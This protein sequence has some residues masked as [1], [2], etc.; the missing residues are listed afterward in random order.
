MIRAPFLSSIYA[1][2]IAGTLIAVIA[3]NAFAPVNF[4]L[5]L[6]IG[7]GLHIAT[8]VYNDIYDTLQGTDKVNVHRNAFSGGSGVLL[9]QPDLISTLFIIA[10]S[11]LV[12]AFAATVGLT[13][14]IQRELWPLLWILYGVSAFLSKYYTAA[15]VKLAYRGLGEL[16]VW[17]AFGPMA[18]LIAAVGQNVGFH[19]YVV[20]LMAVTGLSTLSILIVGQLIDLDADRAGGKYGV[21]VRMGTGFTS[22][23]Y[24]IVQAIII[25][26]IIVAAL[27][28]FHNGWAILLALIPYALLFPRAWK[29]VHSQHDQPDALK[30][31]AGINVQVHFLFSFLL[32]MGLGMILLVNHY[33]MR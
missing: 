18:I 21:A 17:F 14:L 5:I 11:S 23:L 19:P 2:L 12:V 22:W 1:P 8:N 10:R 31:A 3:G 7:T 15:P 16:F 32:I 20:A 28:V 13:L 25:V 4:F 33:Q 26:N 29:I 30:K 6:I 9:D 24:F 27:L